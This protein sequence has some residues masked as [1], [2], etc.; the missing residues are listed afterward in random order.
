MAS[1]YNGPE[2]REDALRPKVGKRAAL[3]AAALI[4]GVVSAIAVT[5]PASANG[6]V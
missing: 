5:P 6:I 2:G 1:L 3:L 4:I